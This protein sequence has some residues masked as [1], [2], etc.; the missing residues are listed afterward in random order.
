AFEALRLHAEANQE[1]AAASQSK[2]PN[3]DKALDLFERAGAA[4]GRVKDLAPPGAYALCLLDHG[5][6]LTDYSRNGD[7]DPAVRK[8]QMVQQEVKR[9]A[10][11]KPLNKALRSLAVDSLCEEAEALTRL[12]RWQDSE[13]RLKQAEA[14]VKDGERD[15]ELLAQVYNNLAWLHMR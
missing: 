6:L 3:R 12:A 4:Y 10:D 15:G 1:L 2:E 11:G 9:E 14:Q 7:A 8:C 13:D 5:R